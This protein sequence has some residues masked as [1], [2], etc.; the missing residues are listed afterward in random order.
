MNL[1]QKRMQKI[2]ESLRQR[3][4][5]LAASLLISTVSSDDMF[6]YWSGCCQGS[7]RVPK[8]LKY[9]KHIQFD[10]ETPT[11]MINFKKGELC[12]GVDFFIKHM[13]GPEDLLFILTHERDHLIL[14]KLFPDVLTPDYPGHLF[15]FGEDVYINAISRRFVPSTLPERFYKEPMEL[16]LTGMHSK[17]DW[18]IFKVDRGTGTNNLIKEAHG[19]LYQQN[20]TLLNAIRE[21]GVKGHHSWGYQSWMQ[22]LFEWHLQNKKR[23]RQQANKKE[24]D[25]PKTKDPDEGAE[26][27]DG[28]ETR[29]QEPEKEPVTDDETGSMDAEAETTDDENKEG[30]GGAEHTGNNKDTE[31]QDVDEE[32]SGNETEED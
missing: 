6:S 15:N 13:D 9:I 8:I 10:Q 1:L 17:I 30:Q 5:D 32:L 18:D 23:S 29:D 4:T 2:K 24:S 7:E 31:D 27:A 12:I 22:L 19:A 25:N 16:L 21:Y 11:A 14:R 3:N 26:N 28:I 20:Y